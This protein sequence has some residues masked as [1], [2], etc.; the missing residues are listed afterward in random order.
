MI[1]AL[2]WKGLGAIAAVIAILKP[3]FWPTKRIKDLE[4][5]VS[6]Y[7]MLEYDL[8]EIVNNIRL[9]QKYSA[10]LQRE[11]QK[12]IQREKTLALHFFALH[13]FPFGPSGHRSWTEPT[14]LKCPSLHSQPC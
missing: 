7:R 2:L 10:D 12:A 4:N 9:K 8:H 13:G 6:G 11:F 1:G 5:V 14:Y 3:I